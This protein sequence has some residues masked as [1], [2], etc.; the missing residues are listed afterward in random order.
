M[1][2]VLVHKP[3]MK[4]FLTRIQTKSFFDYRTEIVIIS[5][6]LKILNIYSFAFK[7]LLLAI[8]MLQRSEILGAYAT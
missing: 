6:Y 3:Y 1:K 4:L 2:Q 7:N 8:R 5:V